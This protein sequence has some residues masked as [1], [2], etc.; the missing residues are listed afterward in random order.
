MSC[1][2]LQRTV[3]DFLEEG[4]PLIGVEAQV[5]EFPILSIPDEDTVRTFLHLYAACFALAVAGLVPLVHSASFI[6]VIFSIEA[7]G[8]SAH[9]RSLLYAT[10]SLRT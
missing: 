6:S 8:G 10:S 9:V 2:G 1:C 7:S 5:S 4:S 3:L